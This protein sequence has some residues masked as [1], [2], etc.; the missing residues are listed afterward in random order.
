VTGLYARV[1]GALLIL[2]AVAG[3]LA[4]NYWN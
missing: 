1:G 4:P 2:L 3:A